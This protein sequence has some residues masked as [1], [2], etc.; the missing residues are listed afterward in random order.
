MPRTTPGSGALLR[1]FFTSNYGVHR[2]EVLSGGSGYAKTDPPK[3]EID[4][5]VTPTTEGVFYPIIKNNSQGIGTIASVRVFVPGVGYYPVFSTTTAADVVV[6]RGAFGSIATD[7]TATVGVHSVFTG[8]YNI[9]DD[10][11][12][13]TDA[14]YGKQGPVGLLTGSTFSGRLFSRKLDPYVPKDKNLVLDDIS[15]EFTGIAG[16]QFELSENLGIVTA[17]YNNVNLGVDI[18]NNPFVLIN[19]IVQTPGLDFEIVGTDSNKINFLSGVPRAGRIVKVGLETGSGYYTPLKAS[20][21]AGIGTTGA[22]E[23]AKLTGRGQGYRTP[24]EITVRSSVGF[25]AS[26]VAV[27]G[28]NEGTTIGITTAQYNMFTG[29]ATFQTNGAH[30]FAKDERVRITGA[31]FTFSP[32]SPNRNI[33]TFGYDYIT[34]I[35]TVNVTGG[36]YIGTGTNSNK[37]LLVTQVQV[38]DGISTYTFREDAY[39]IV[40]VSGP[41]DVNID[42]GV[43]TQPLT[44]VSGGLVRAG[45]DTN[46]LEAVNEVGFDILGVTTNTFRVFVGVSTFNHDYVTGGVVERTQAGIVTALNIVSGGQD[47]FTTKKVA[48]IEN[49]PSDGIT[50]VTIHGKKLSDSLGIA[51][52]YYTASTGIATIQ[53]QANHGMSVNDVVKLTG[54]GFSTPAG[55]ITLPPEGK[56]QFFAV[57]STPSTIDYT[58][59]LGIRSGIH[60]HQAVGMGSY[61]KYENHGLVTDD[62]VTVTGIA[63]TFASAPGVEITNVVYDNTSGIATFTTKNSHNLDLDDCVVLSGIA[64]TCDYSPSLGISTVAYD[65]TTGVMTVT[66]AAPH[67]YTVGGKAGTVVLTGLGFTCQLDN[68]ARTHYYPRRRSSTFDTSVPIVSVGATT[69]TVDVGYAGARDQYPHTF[70][71][72]ET[73]AVIT[74]GAYDHTF[75]RSVEGALRNGGDFP[76]AFVTSISE[77]IFSGGNYAHT[78]TESSEEAII[79]GGGYNHTFVSP[80]DDDCIN[81]VGGG[82]TT[83]THAD[84]NPNSGDLTLTVVGHGLSGPTQHTVTDAEYT[85]NTGKLT[86]TLPTHGF[87]VGDSVRIAQGGITFTCAMDNHATNH[88]YPRANDPANGQWLGIAA[89]TTNT[90]DVY[91]GVT[92]T[93]YFDVSGADYT[94]STG[95]MTMTVGPH[96]L[97][98]GTSIK[99]AANSLTFSCGLD[100]YGSNK[101][102]PRTTDPAYE[103]ALSIVGVGSTTFS[104]NVG[105]STIVPFDVAFAHYTPTT[106]IMTCALT[107]IHGLQVGQ[108]IRIK[109]ES[110]GFKCNKNAYTT[111]HF[112]PRPSDPYYN[113]AVPIVGAAGTLLTLQVGPSTSWDYTH[114]F[115]PNLGSAVGSII[116]GGDYPYQFVSAASS[117][118]ITGGNYNHD[119]VSATPNGLERTVQRIGIAT[120]SLSFKCAKDGY[121]TVHDYPRTTDPAHNAELG[122][123]SVTADTLSVRVGVSTYAVRQATGATYDPSTGEMVVTVGVGHSYYAQSGHTI[124]TATY[125]ASAGVLEVTVPNHGFLNGEYV[126]FDDGSIT[127]TCDKDNYGSNHAYPRPSDSYRNKWLPVYHVGVNTFSVFVGV[128]TTSNH[129]FQSA[130]T[131]GL[132]KAAYTVGVGTGSYTFTCARDNHATKHAYPRMDDPAHN[133]VL[134]IGSTSANTITLQVGVTTQVTNAITTATYVPSTGDLVITSPD[135]GYSGVQTYTPNL[136]TYNPS[137]GVLRLTLDNNHGWQVGERVKLLDDSLVFKCD[138][139]G[140]ATEH[141][142]PRGTDPIS[143]KWVPIVGTGTNFFDINVGTSLTTFYSP[144]S[145]SFDPITGLMTVG[146]G[147][148]HNLRK[149]QSVRLKTRGF[150]FT[151]GMD[152]HATNHYYPRATGLTGPDPAYNTAVKITSTTEQTITLD[153][154]TSSNQSDH[155]FV[156]AATSSIIAGGEY[157][158]VFVRADQG[159]LQKSENTI[160]IATNGLTWRCA[161]DN[162]ATDHTY[163][164]TTDPVHGEEIGVVT[165][166]QNTFTVNVGVTTIQ[167]LN[168]SD[169][170]YDPST[171]V[172]VLTT[173]TAHGL[174]T[175]Q[176]GVGIATNSLIYTC[177]MDQN[178]SE[179]SYPRTTDP[180]HN[181]RL[182]IAATT[183]NTLTVNVGTST[184]VPYDVDGADYNSV[185]GIMT[186][187]IGSHSLLANT[188][189]KFRNEGLIFTCTKDGNT[190]Q[191]GYP[192]DGDPYFGGVEITRVI[193]N[194]TIEANVGVT[195]VPSYYVGGGTIQGAIIAPRFNNNS[196][197]GEDYAASGT[198][199]DKV[200]SN[201][202]FV[203]NVGI[204]TCQHFYNR[205]GTAFKGKRLASS[206]EEGYS[207]FDVLEAFDGANIRVNAG[208]TTEN[209]YYTGGGSVDKPIFLD[210]VEPDPYYNLPLNY[211]DGTT[212]IGTNATVDLRVNVDGDIRE[213]NLT[214][215][216]IAYKVEDSLT[217]AGIVTDPRVGILTEFRLNVI[218]LDNDKFSGFYPGQFILF[219][220]ISKFF[221]S[222]R[223]KF[224]LSV[225]TGGTTEIL[226]LKTL[227]GS[228]MDITNNIFIYINDILQTPGTSYIFKGSRVIFSEAPKSN[229]K[230]SVFYYRG[231][232]R[233][234]ETIEPP[235]TVKAGDTVQIK[236]NKE[237]IFDIDQFE[238]TGKRIVASDVLETFAYN[239]IG[240]DTNPVAERPL[241]WEKQKVDRVLSGVLV[242]KARPSL[243]S[244]VTPATRLIHKVDQ[245]DGFIRVQNAFPLFS[246][247]DLV[248]QAERNAQIFEDEEI[249]PGIVTSIVSTASSISDIV[250]VDGGSGYKNIVNPTVNISASGITR[251][252]PIKDWRFDGISG[253]TNVVDFKALTD[254]EP[255]VAVG[256]SS[257]YIN[258]K[259][260]SFWERGTIGFGGTVQ[261]HCVGVGQSSGYPTK[262]VVAGG[263]YG[264][265]ARAAGF[266]NSLT[267]FSEIELRELRQIPALNL[268]VEYPS[269]FEETFN[270]VIYEPVVDT[271]VA[272]GAGGSVF[273]AVGVTSDVFFSNY[274]N[275]VQDLNSVVY[276]QGEFIAVGNGGEIVASNDGKVWSPKASNTPYNLRDII[277]DGNRF[278]TVGDN[279]TIGVSSDKNYWEPWS[280]QQYNNAVHPATFDFKVLKYIDNLYI[281]ISTI[282]VLYYSFDLINWNRRDVPH[283]NEIRDIV[284]T[285]FGPSRGQRIISVGSGTTQ[286]YA[287]P[288]INRA[289][290]TASVTNGIV[291]SVTITDGGFGYEYGS[292]PSVI[293]ESDVPKKEEILSFRTEG[294]F[295]VIVGVNTWM[296]GIGFSVP[297]RLQFTLKSE[298]NDNTNLGYGYSSLNTLGVNYSGLQKDDYF[299]IYDSPLVVGHALT[300]ITTSIGGYANYPANKVGIISAGENLEGVFRVERV[301]TG[302]AVSGLVTVTCAFQPGPNN[303][304]D[305]QVGVGTTATIDTYWGKYSWGK[306]FGYQ[307][308]GAGTPQAFDVNV[309]AGMVGLSTA[310]SVRRIQPLS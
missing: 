258:T 301:T 73:G 79:V 189:F 66:T 4:G 26:V 88:P 43:G 172:V 151:C 268:T 155:I 89:T 303:N 99:I 111:T 227:A 51:N 244:R 309:D 186:L 295:G 282:G 47:Y 272:V 129:I 166:T 152:N 300:G 31:G 299:V 274:P 72:A 95:I 222:N 254:Q 125:N 56:N 9:V 148:A 176:G 217:V 241:M 171:G 200:I 63:V 209:F 248:T 108:S 305:I 12:F 137:T 141:T 287:D 296:P 150:K 54:I 94:P 20:A 70:V 59:D 106:G 275:T 286:F 25:G 177:T 126:K 144:T 307:N 15:L 306:I 298:F 29:I 196:A 163:P 156:A 45:V 53:A 97:P 263:E 68:G 153:V 304:S 119:F 269:T 216:G 277:Y 159:C 208:F 30:G 139:D 19:N 226:S 265:L 257:Q 41:N 2:I 62:F 219:D 183:S 192:K 168:V 138:L 178:A 27:L 123:T 50:T 238:R 201:R 10:D 17:L 42:V 198:F 134:G 107:V 117:A 310:A 175:V 233:D 249:T 103:S 46:I 276:A 206:I 290:A 308:R 146:F 279:G 13:F 35:A 182:A 3:I 247:I 174:T 110:L 221:N 131:N 122:I 281:G 261:F 157:T 58:V 181:A 240:I 212:G 188:N 191:H 6:E 190:Q 169:A 237:N 82:T 96:E 109:N 273:T 164:R 162:Y 37:H 253:V 121:A 170:T 194:T 83:P 105:P 211:I 243:K 114:A 239:S 297:P 7:H 252:D 207:G 225:T 33:N 266:G 292:S 22:L 165:T 102:Y 127:F 60:T 230:C 288:V 118:V 197:S 204:A 235:L 120:G 250:I 44:Y 21:V 232:A 205:I 85:P 293:I 8:D 71:T 245:Q 229:S 179:H 285:N 215:E 14:P 74:G 23:I 140:R 32:L 251:Q 24:P 91:V 143:D 128:G 203:A 101:T 224:T 302:D 142:Y 223:R 145:G 64:F 61:I 135:H 193:N 256:G 40:D 124:T 291:T 289:T 38:S 77:S 242:P 116:S 202:E 259:S 90:F 260:G 228:D 104:V 18:N 210:F 234:V 133:A 67:G 220:D 76:H 195:T 185:V 55:N 115:V 49:T 65:N 80:A 75:V 69:I 264:S 214:E 267:S 187:A 280:T 100:Q 294:D 132:K 136:V 199:V 284:A 231:S 236:E 11:I 78:Y 36:H 1:P 270:D 28:T 184:A 112:Y 283:T 57:K 154:G 98:T 52:V 84:Y 48:W 160:G 5:T 93:K 255:I 180:A 147:T 39:P 81:V 246:E 34:G 16:T 278:I 87:L 161:Q 271:W 130:T 218:E 149:G 92:S 167:R 158:H 113:T 262:Y 173:D 213:F 86:L